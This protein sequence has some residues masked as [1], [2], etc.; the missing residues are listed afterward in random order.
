MGDLLGDILNSVTSGGAAS[1]ALGDILGQV[2]GGQTIQQATK[3]PTLPTRQR[4]GNPHAR[5]LTSQR[6]WTPSTVSQLA[7]R[8][9]VVSTWVVS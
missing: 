1:G 2:L 7:L 4:H 5:G 8:V 3:K 9:K 6:N